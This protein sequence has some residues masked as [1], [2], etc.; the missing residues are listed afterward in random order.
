MGAIVYWHGKSP[1]VGSWALFTGCYS[2]LLLYFFGFFMNL[3]FRNHMKFRWI[4]S[5]LW[6]GLL[7]L[8]L[9]AAAAFFSGK[10]ALVAVG[11]F[12]QAT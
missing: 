5:R 9:A 1:S 3:L 2:L 11:V 12:A 10:L 6:R 8:G 4:D 7:A